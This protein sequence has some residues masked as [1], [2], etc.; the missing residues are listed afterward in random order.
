MF[1]R[2]FGRYGR[3]AVGIHLLL[4][5]E[6]TYKSSPNLQPE[7]AAVFADLLEMVFSTSTSCVEGLKSKDPDQNIARNVDVAFLT[8]AKRYS[9]RWNTIVES[10]T[11]KI[12]QE[13]SLIYSSPEIGSLRQ[14]LGVQDRPFQ[15]ILDSRSHKLAEG[16]FEWFNNTLY[17]FTVGSS[18][19]LLV[20]GEPGCGK[21]ALSQWTMDRLQESNEHEAWNII[22]YTIRADIPVATLPLRIL[23][24]ILH[25]M[26][27]HCVSD[28]RIQ[29]NILI[30]AAKAAQSALD[31][32]K[33]HRVEENLW[34]GIQAGL[35]ADIQY[36]FVLDGLDQIK[37]GPSLGAK[38]L[39]RFSETLSLQNSGSKMIAFSR[40]ITQI[41]STG[42]FQHF[43]IQATHTQT[44]LATYV[45][46]TLSSS[47]DSDHTNNDQ[48]VSSVANVVTDII[49]QSK[50]SFIWAELALEYA[51]QQKTLNRAVAA[52]HTLPDSIPKLLEFH[53]QHLDLS[54]RE[55]MSVLSWLAAAE[56]PLLIEEIDQ[57]LLVDHNTPS[58]IASKPAPTNAWSEALS[59]LIMT[60]DGV[61]S[62]AHTCIRDHVLQQAK[63]PVSRSL[64]NIG[65]AHFDLLNKCLAWVQL[66]VREESGLAMDKLSSSERNH[67]FDKYPILEY[68]ARY[69]LS[70][71]LNSNLVNAKGDFKFGASSKNLIP[72]TVL[73]SR[74]ELTCRE[75]QFTRSSVVELY[76]LAT[77]I[78]R[79]V[80]GDKSLA[81]LQSLLFTAQASKLAN[82]SHADEHCFEAWQISQELLGQSDPITLQ[83]MEMMTEMFSK[84]GSMTPDQE[85]TL[86]YLILADSEVTGIDFDQRMKHLG[87]MV[88]IYQASGDDEPGLHLSKQFYQVIAQKYGTNSR[89]A[90]EAA[91]FLTD[92]FSTGSEEMNRDI[93]R[94]KYDNMRNTMEVTNDRRIQ[95]SLYLA[96]LY[97]KQGDDAQ[98]RG[99]L[100]SLWSGL[101]SR[102]IDT[103]DTMDKK[104]NVALAYHQYLHRQGRDQEADAVMRELVAD[105]EVTGVHS[106]EMMQGVR[107]LRS[108]THAMHMYDLERSLSILMWHYYKEANEEY[109]PEAMSLALWLAESTASAASINGTT[110]LM[111]GQDQG[112]QL[113]VE[114]IDS[115][116][117]SPENLSVSTLILCHS[118][119]SNHMRAGDWV[120]AND[121][122]KAALRYIWPTVE[123][124]GSHPK[125]SRELAPPVADL[126]LALAYCHFRR[127]N[128]EQA[129]IVYAN[130]FGSLKSS[131]NVPVASVMAVAKAVV[132][133]YETTFQFTRALTLLNELSSFLATRLGQSH[134]HTVDNMYLEATLAKRLNM[135]REAKNTYQRIYACT[136]YDD[137]IALEGFEAAFALISLYEKE[138]QWK[139]ALGI[140]RHL[141]PSLAS[142]DNISRTD[143]ATVE[144][145]LEKTFVGYMTTLSSHPNDT[146]FSEHHKVYSDYIAACRNVYGPT[147]PKTLSATLLL[148]ELCE[149][150]KS[151][152]DQAI[153]LYKKSLETN[154][155]V[156]ASQL[157]KGLEQMTYPLPITLKHK[158]AQL[159]VQ[160]KDS[161]SDARSLYTEEFQLAKKTQGYYSRTTLSWLRELAL[162]HSHQGTPASIQQGNALLHTYI[163][164]I[165]HGESAET[166]T[167]DDW[168]RKIGTIYVEC[169]FIDGGNAVLDELRQR[170]VSSP[171]KSAKTL[172]DQRDAVFVSAFEEAFSRRASSDVIMD[173]M[174]REMQTRQE[175]SKNLSSHDFI[176]ALVS[177][178]RLA[179]LQ[180]DQK[181]DHAAKRTRDRLYEYFC[182]TLSA[183]QIADRGIVQHF[184]QI[185]LREADNEKYIAK[186]LNRTTK[187]VRDLCKASKF[188]EASDITG[189]LHSFLHLTDG[190]DNYDNIKT[191]TKLCLYLSGNNITKCEGKSVCREMSLK[192]KLLLQEI[193][194]S[195]KA[196]GIEII[197][198][199]FT[200]LNDMI[201]LFGEYEMF[202]ELEA[203]LTQLWTSRIVQRTWFPDVVVWVGRRLVETRFC[204]GSVDSSIQLC[205]DICYNLRQ[206]TKLL[207]GLFTAS[208]DHKSATTL[209]EAALHDLLGDA[210][211]KNHPDA[212]D[213]ASQHLELLRRAQARLGT[214]QS[215]SRASAHESL[216]AHVTEKFGLKPEQ[217][218]NIGEVHG[219]EAFGMWSRPRRFSID[220]DDLDDQ[221]QV[222]QNRLRE[223]SGPGT[224][225]GSGAPRRISVQ[226]L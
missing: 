183:T 35:E 27:D 216:I 156:S 29:E 117:S 110:N 31:G 48:L 58:F 89:K 51:R 154:E 192:S 66:S 42:G 24:G 65:D 21:S 138:N 4:Q 191:A 10:S 204:R 17:D 116:C 181:R 91:D 101:N 182:S 147:H 143:R 198:L 160:K 122:T 33:D 130:A 224:M 153:S 63:T 151:S 83:C 169:G 163:T 106:P 218:Q 175:F 173:E 96:Q 56:R 170:V 47:F 7:A 149:T 132:E 68:T 78:R 140:Y 113:M 193:M 180:A 226:A 208:G 8:Y 165:L 194:E 207:S 69:W 50:G 97:E 40:P 186:I 131:E 215:T 168:A 107:L 52:V 217:V 75:S 124:Q 53:I 121:C 139:A 206:M 77:D 38:F 115:I 157:S 86:R 81:F 127:L 158:L 111:N 79:S 76:R 103:V 88:S 25:Q 164:D 109:S 70:H 214:G 60:R 126:A 85:A 187:L 108:E 93:A 80:L 105:L 159:Y 1:E 148:A 94:T 125:F 34:Q 162:A 150:N 190:L 152:R 73:F 3:V 71:F 82:A 99:V 119:A 120:G 26:L 205:R 61:I 18:P 222:H 174:A 128:L 195:S 142:S 134:K 212:A 129:T 19:V 36:M 9:N 15:F 12:V 197:D 118:L 74:L 202:D 114:L 87:M 184:Y 59:P 13:S 225:N 161:G 43:T 49:N 5:Y 67:L 28:K 23:K 172:R 44:D 223:S 57:L 84:R 20:T 98:A 145:S 104:A 95:H 123:D 144:R 196:I 30:H 102:E 203:T 39:S 32:A 179:N 199:P 213:V 219:G 41:T 171:D 176:P 54:Q 178:N 166:D 209:H 46:E 92:H 155:W 90:S 189:V 185:C 37:G 64:F 45:S 135:D 141:W 200:D 220:V 133:F 211:A 11:A 210:D 100:S 2:I 146:E 201:T 6:D 16:S 14:F 22:P 72:D 55:T 137:K 221:G 62:F 167:M 112:S 188:Q 136:T 177:G